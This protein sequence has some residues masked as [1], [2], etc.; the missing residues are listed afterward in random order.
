MSIYGPF[1]SPYSRSPLCFFLSCLFFGLDGLGLN[2]Q[3]FLLFQQRGHLY[4]IP[5]SQ[6]SYSA[7][8]PVMSGPWKVLQI[9]LS[10][11]FEGNLTSMHSSFQS[12]NYK[13]IVRKKKKWATLSS[14]SPSFSLDEYGLWRCNGTEDMASK[15]NSGEFCW[16]AE[17]VKRQGEWQGTKKDYRVQLLF[18]SGPLPRLSPFS[19]MK[20]LCSFNGIL[21]HLD[22][23]TF[24]AFIAQIR[25]KWRGPGGVGRFFIKEELNELNWGNAWIWFAYLCINLWHYAELV[26]PRACQQ[27]QI[28]PLS[29]SIVKQFK[30]LFCPFKAYQFNVDDW[31][32][33]HKECGNWWISKSCWET[34]Q[35]RAFVCG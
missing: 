16:A 26:K 14:L 10:W 21:S 19:Q 24:I 20:F 27:W 32:L 35:R 13:G 18:M 9:N 7:P 33:L 2:G 17:I 5:G 15:Y 3:F 6:V 4:S 30:P 29:R 1:S 25:G 31:Q 12:N 28:I 8:L 22:W 11:C 23:F 34:Y